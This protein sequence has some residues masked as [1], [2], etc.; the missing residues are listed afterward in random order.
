MLRAELARLE[1]AL[2]ALETPGDPSGDP[3]G[4]P[5]SPPGDP[6]LRGGPGV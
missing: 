5:L 2:Q 6:Q 1:Q 3:P 4:D